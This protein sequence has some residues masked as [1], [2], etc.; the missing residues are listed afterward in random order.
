MG[1]KK[2]CRLVMC[3]S[4]LHNFCINERVGCELPPL[5]VDAAETSAHGGVPMERN[6]SGYNG[7]ND[8]LPEQLLHG[9]DHFDDVDPAE[10]RRVEAR[11]RRTPEG[12]LP[13]DFL[14]GKVVDQGLKR[15]APAQWNVD[16]K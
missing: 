10:L 15:P 3:L 7:F 14:V 8:A 12:K 9:S 16:N 13:R 2:I 5:S 4:R 11:A 1:L 6:P